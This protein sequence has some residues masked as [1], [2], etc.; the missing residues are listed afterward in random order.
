[1]CSSDLASVDKTVRLWR[2]TPEERARLLADAPPF[3]AEAW[4]R[5]IA[6]PTPEELA[7]LDDFLRELDE[8]RQH[9]LKR[10]EERLAELGE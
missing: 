6:P 2:A 5:N 4:Q 7:D 9:D 10:Q 8:M 1:M 3:D